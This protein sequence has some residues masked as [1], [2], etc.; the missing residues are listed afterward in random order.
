MMKGL[1]EFQT[2]RKVGLKVVEVRALWQQYKERLE[3]DTFAR[4]AARDHL[5]L[6]V[7]QYDELIARLHQ[8]LDDLSVLEY[9]EKISAQINTTT[10]NIGEMQAKRVDLLQKAGLLD[11]HDL[12]DELAER[13]EREAMILDILRNDL[14]TECQIHVRDKLTRLSGNVEGTVVDSEEAD[15]E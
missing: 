4:D 2:A 3:A 6:M 12:G 15:D 11:A 9:D 13:E 7:K 1:S 14:C 8:N 10:K 5:N